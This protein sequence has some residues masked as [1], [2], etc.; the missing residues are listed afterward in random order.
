VPVQTDQAAENDTNQTYHTPA[1]INPTIVNS[2]GNNS[3]AYNDSS[4][5][6]DLIN[7]TDNSSHGLTGTEI[8][9]SIQDFVA[10][11]EEQVTA[12]DIVGF[13]NSEVMGADVCESGTP[14]PPPE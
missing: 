12:D 2:T 8:K 3:Q 7:G 11:S 5:D 13:V 9:R 6:A 1:T 14:H 10:A 4:P